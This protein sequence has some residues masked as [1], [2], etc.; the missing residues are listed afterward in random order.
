MADNK[1]IQVIESWDV[2]SSGIIAELRHS[3]NGLPSGTIIQ[4]PSTGKEWRIESRILYSHTCGK[5]KKFSNETTIL[6]FLSFG[7]MEKQI[8]SAKNMLDKE[9]DNIFIINC[10]LLD[11]S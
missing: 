6:S 1:T 5:Q 11:I 4:S 8:A 9:E 7:S 3:F 10:N 2:T